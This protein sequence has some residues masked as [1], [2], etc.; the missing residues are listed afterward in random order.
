MAFELSR[1]RDCTIDFWEISTMLHAEEWN[2][3]K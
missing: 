2:V 3:S 1:M